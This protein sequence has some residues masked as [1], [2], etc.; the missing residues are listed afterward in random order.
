MK[1]R[2]TGAQWVQHSLLAHACKADRGRADLDIDTLLGWLLQLLLLHID[3]AV[4]EGQ[5]VDGDAA[6]PGRCLQ[7]EQLLW[8]TGRQTEDCRQGAVG[9]Q[10]D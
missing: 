3:N 8:L 1:L 10:A 2:L 5:A 4:L 7:E 9:P 6:P